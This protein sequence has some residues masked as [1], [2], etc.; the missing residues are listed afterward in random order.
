[1]SN[2]HR[3]VRESSAKHP[4][5][6]S[7]R[8]A[9]PR[10]S[11]H[12]QSN[13]FGELMSIV[14]VLRPLLLALLL[15]PMGPRVEL[16]AQQSQV[17]GRVVTADDRPVVGASVTVVGT[18]IGALTN[19]QGRFT[20]TV[21]SANATLRISRLGYGSETVALDGRT[22]VVVTL[23][24]Q[25]VELEGLV[26][27]G[28]GTQRR[29]DVT[30]SVASISADRLEE[31][32]NTSVLQ[33]LQGAVPGITVQTTGAGAEPSASVI[34][35]GRN[36]ITASNS[37]LVVVDGIPYNGPLSEINQ[38]DVASID[39]LKDASAAAI[40]GSRGANGVIL[41]TTRKGTGEP[42][43]SYDGYSGIQ[44]I[45]HL[46]R[47]MTAEEFAAAKCQRVRGG[48][49]CE[50]AFTQT[51]LANL[52]AGRSVNWIDLATRTG[53]QQQHNLA[54]TG[55][56]DGTTY[57]VAG[58]L[59]DVAGIARNDEFQ[60]YTLRVNLGQELGSVLQVG[61]STQLSYADRGGMEA[62]FTD[63][64]RMN[65]LTNVYNEDGTL[66][67]R[68]WAED[69]FFLN[70]LQGLLATSDDITRRVFTSNF[71][72][73][74]LPFLPG[75]SFRV[76]AGLD[77]ANGKAGRYYGMDTGT[78]SSRGGYAVT[79][80]STRFDWTLE[81]ILRYTRSIGSHNFDLTTLYSQQ[82]DRLDSESLR[83]E[84]F[85]NDILG[86]YQPHLARS[87]DPSAGVTESALLSQMARLNYSYDSRYLVTLTA[88]RDGYSG[89]GANHKY[90]L[91]PSV[92][93]G[94]NVSDEGFWP[95]SGPFT[96][97]KLR[98]SYGRNGNQAISPY[99]TL[100]RL[101]DR[102]YVDGSET[103]P[104]F[105]PATL[106]NPNLR[107]ETTTGLN[108]G[109]DFA[110]LG[111]R[112]RGSV[113]GYSSS[114]SDLLL[115]RAISPTHGIDNVLQ[116]IGE[117]ANRGVELQLSTT[118]VQTDRFTWSTDFNVSMNR[119]EIVDLYGDGQDDLVNQW[120]IGQPVDVN[121]GYR[122]AGV[123]QEG[124]DIANSAQPTAKPGD[125]RVLDLNGD[126]TI[127]PQDRTFLG[128]LQ[129][130]FV[131][132]LGS[133]LRYGNLS[134]TGFLHTVQGITRQNPLLSTSNFGDEGRYNTVLLPYWTPENPNTNYPANRST[135]NL[136]LPV[137]FYEDASFIR[138]K[139]LTLSYD[140]P[141][142]LTGRF[143]A[144][145]LRAYVSGRNLWTHT[146]WTGLDPELGSQ[147]G[148]PL[149][150]VFIG[151]INLRF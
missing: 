147:T 88:R 123:W 2:D 94:W 125:I 81:N 134:L 144:N 87:L 8:G 75:L 11:E 19:E 48:T 37:P 69:P 13:P 115:R 73:L 31:A 114:T 1:M 93:L 128:S 146:K 70:P 53:T 119:S 105:I 65:P 7:P 84:G 129:P 4:Q 140:V 34:I 9:L 61:T 74:E 46:P 89:F 116:N 111:D 39:V 148:V 91:F 41:I 49:N 26:V 28:Y 40:Y 47:M 17:Q 137:G 118:N 130:D 109:A 77:Y 139:D 112:V 92:A 32:A 68:P 33:A 60:R 103:L 110:L 59:L 78:G 22:N 25:A 149:E 82:R 145:S 120:F 100:A 83:A 35:R 142:S 101:S 113:D 56:S 135:V 107:W 29:S 133:T 126:G 108:V 85:P 10:N 96:S 42:R 141:T 72:Q 99:Q 55:G 64:F 97:L 58:S 43:F 12:H 98:A 79:S 18:S 86:Y 5:T 6:S 3:R 23:T 36:S 62:S 151:G 52:Q 71:A 16:E 24:E 51:E 106:G 95:A 14:R 30:G 20:L 127:D 27:V 21:P 102:S 136:G 66:T 122:F 138:L 90:G 15:V 76:N 150:R 67:I 117:T 131:A 124:D 104:G 132:G 54:V 44:E 143:G 121:Y 80:N 57:Y 38:S 63:A 50:S 45:A